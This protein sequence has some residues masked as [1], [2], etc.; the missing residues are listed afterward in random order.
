MYFDSL[1]Q[2]IWMNGHGIYVWSSFAISALVMIGLIV[3]PLRQKQVAM[4][5]IELQIKLQASKQAVKQ[6]EVSDAPHS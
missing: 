3:K 5:N 2:L 6:K 1:Q 4:R